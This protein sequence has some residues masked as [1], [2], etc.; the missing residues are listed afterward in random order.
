MEIFKLINIYDLELKSMDGKEGRFNLNLPFDKATW[1]FVN[2]LRNSKLSSVSI[3][4]DNE[5]VV[6]SINEDDIPSFIQLKKMYPV[7]IVGGKT[8]DL[9][10]G[11]SCNNNCIHCVVKPNIFELRKCGSD[12]HID[13]EKGIVCSD[14]SKEEL[15]ELIKKEI[16][17][18]EYDNI[19]WTGGEPLIREDFIDILR[20]IR[21]LYP[22]IKHTIQ[23]N[24]RALEDINL[25]RSL[26]LLDINIDFVIAIH[27]DHEIHNRV[28]NNRKE[29]GN[30]FVETTKGI[31]NLKEVYGND[32]KMRSEIVLSN[33]NI[34]VCYNS[35]VDQYMKYGIKEIGISY[36]HLEG[37]S[38]NFV[39]RVCPSLDKVEELMVRLN[40]FIDKVGKNNI[41][42]LVEE[43]PRCIFKRINNTH[44]KDM[45]SDKDVN[46]FYLLDSRTTDFSGYLND[47]HLKN[48]SCKKCVYNSNCRGLWVESFELNRKY[49]T[50]I[51]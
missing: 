4:H 46:I 33:F 17:T 36:P 25:V 18:L 1:N 11:Y 43:I 31:Q 24:G 20:T 50:P 22:F 49:L 2:D 21:T 29:K 23:T 13:P 14:P 6:I 35:V 42:I 5:D 48:I 45:G 44:I 8:F 7:G 3:D 39:K 37:Y 19:V 40:E 47:V 41:N 9:K 34:D 27:G 15:L 51:I 32:L 30:P 38:E 26:W 28:V 16:G 10:V 12:I